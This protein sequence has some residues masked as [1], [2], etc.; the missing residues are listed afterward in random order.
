MREKGF[1]GLDG[2]RSRST[3]NDGR[4]E[5]GSWIVQIR[6]YDVPRRGQLFCLSFPLPVLLSRIHLRFM[7]GPGTL[8]LLR[9]LLLL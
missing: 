3:P 1:S 7:K 8:V 4:R 5:G 6:N 9:S 2:I